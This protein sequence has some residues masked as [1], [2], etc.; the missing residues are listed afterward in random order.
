MSIQPL[1]YASGKPFICQRREYSLDGYVR[2]TKV[3]ISFHFMTVL[4]D[5]SFLFL[6]LTILYHLMQ[7]MQ[8]S[9]GDKLGL[10]KKA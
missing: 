10:C 7:L 4:L 9:D 1:Q 6:D 8:R 5:A 3:H 2:Y